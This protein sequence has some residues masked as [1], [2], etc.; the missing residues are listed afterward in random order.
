MDGYDKL[1]PYGFP[2]H[3]CIDG[4]SRKMLR[5]RLSKSNNCP[6]VIANWYLEAVKELGGSP[7]KVRTDC[8]TE[9][10]IAAAAQCY[11]MNN[12]RAHI[13]GTSPHNQ[14]IEGWWAYLR[15][16]RT[17]WWINFFMDLMEQDVF[18]PGNQ[19][20]MEGLWFCFSSVIQQDL[21]MVVD[22]W[23]THYI[24]RSRHET[25]SGR[26]DELFFLPELHSWRYVLNQVT[27]QECQFLREN[28]LTSDES[29]N[30]FLKLMNNS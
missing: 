22:H 15:R 29:R 18:T 2:I 3:G 1:K 20:Q 10:G 12:E 14:R 9:N 8:G 5:L 17:S 30:E 27:E 24:R 4:F 7:A 25:V 28:Y 6:S 16:S 11:F 13:Y 26:P 19:L 21:N 23:N